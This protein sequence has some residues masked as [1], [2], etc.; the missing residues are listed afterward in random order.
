MKPKSPYVDWWAKLK[1]DVPP[2]VPHKGHC[3]HGDEARMLGIWM[4]R[5][6]RRKPRVKIHPQKRRQRI[7]AWVKGTRQVRVEEFHYLY[8]YIL[9]QKT[10]AREKGTVKLQIR[11]GLGGLTLGRPF[12]G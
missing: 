12:R 5:W 7:D 11:I 1:R 2:V 4:R 3:L 6:I 8:D 9:K 10:L